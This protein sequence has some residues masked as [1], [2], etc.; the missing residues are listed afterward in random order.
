MSIMSSNQI[1]V[2][3]DFPPLTGYKMQLKKMIA[4]DPK[5]L[6]VTKLQTLIIYNCLSIMLFA[7]YFYK[8]KFYDLQ[9]FIKML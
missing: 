1:K 4:S 8:F 2:I 6:V 7:C 5:L 3:Q 9:I